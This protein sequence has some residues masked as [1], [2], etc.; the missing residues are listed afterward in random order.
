MFSC[1]VSFFTA[2]AVLPK[3][4]EGTSSAVCYALVASP[5]LTAPLGN[6]VESKAPV[7]G[8]EDLWAGDS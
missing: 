5:T 3:S 8:P 2:K 4:Y 1:L 7:R 6:T